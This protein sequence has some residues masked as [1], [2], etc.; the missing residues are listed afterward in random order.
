M[1]TA[2]GTV[3]YAAR[4]A[5]GAT[6]SV[7]VPA[8]AVVLVR[9]PFD[10]GWR[11]T[12]DGRPAAVMPGDMLDQAILVPAGRHVIRLDYRDPWIAIGLACSAAALA[13]LAGVG[14]AFRT[15]DGA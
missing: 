13:V 12:V 14:V 10:A 9:T 15:R 2:S 7:R 3:A 6:I 1:A 11:A 5:Q 8:R 4:G